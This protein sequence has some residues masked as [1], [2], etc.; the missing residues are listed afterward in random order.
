MLIRASVVVMAALGGV[1]VARGGMAPDYDFQWATIGAAGNPNWTTTEGSPNRD[2]GGVAY[3]YRISKLEVTTSQWLEFVNTIGP[4]D[5]AFTAQHLAPSVWGASESVVGPPGS[6]YELRGDV[7]NAEMTQLNGIT[8]RTAAM[9][10]NWLHNDKAPAM[11]AITNGAYDTSTFT[12]N[13]DGS[14]NDQRTHSPDAKFWIPTLD[15]WMKAVYYDPHRNGPDQGGWWMY[16]YSSDTPPTPG[17]PD[18]LGAQTGFGV[19][20]T[21]DRRPVFIPLGSYPDAVT[22]WGL[23]DASGGNSEWTAD[24]RPGGRRRYMGTAAGP[25]IASFDEIWYS[26]STSFTESLSFRV[27]SRVPTPGATLVLVGCMCIHFSR[28]RIRYVE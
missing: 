8:W 10:C 4:L 1:D 6:R 11:W 25:G 2:R 16:P 5:H 24:W 20:G 26:H 9:Y 13:P 7:P 17:W 21:D 23:L 15:E 14:L 27:A 18:E 19:L 3:E 22:P 28:R 12:E